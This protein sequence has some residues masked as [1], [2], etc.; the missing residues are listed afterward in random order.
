MQTQCQIQSQI[1]MKTI[2]TIALLIMTIGK[3]LSAQVLEEDV[4]DHKLM[5]NDLYGIKEYTDALPHL[6]WLSNNAPDVDE[7]VHIKGVRAIDK[8]LKTA[9]TEEKLELQ[10]LALKLYEQR[11]EHFGLN[12]KVKSLQLTAIYRYF[13]KNV[14]QYDRLLALYETSISENL[15]MMSNA[16]FL[17]YFD[18]LRRAKKYK[19]TLDE[20]L[21]LSNYAKIN[22]LMVKRDKKDGY[23]TKIESFLSEAVP[24]DCERIE[25]VFGSKL[26]DNIESL[27]SAKMLV[28]LSLKED[29]DDSETL[30]TALE[31]VS[32]YDPTV[33]MLT[34]MAKRAMKKN[35]LKD[36]EMYFGKALSQNDDLD[37][38]SDIYLNLAKIYTVKKQKQKAS[39]FAY[40]SIE[41]NQNKSAYTL[42]GNLYMS[43]FDECVGEKD[44]VVR[45][46]V[47]I[48]AYD[49]F[50]KANDTTN[51]ALAQA[52]FPSM[53]EIHMNNYA[54]GQEV[55]VDCWFKETV[56]LQKR[57]E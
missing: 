55:K 53:Q 26:E 34:Y 7:N 23:D 35:E 32:K 6:K 20:E 25:Q 11:I 1:I 52:N 9:P 33:N 10:E 18:I 3:N 38:E 42:I 41:A 54:L 48:A 28:K 40:K 49:M 31:I 51:M 56:S 30:E 45:R 19:L 2:L 17:S 57:T 39:E 37:V 50:K 21:V 27:G 43:S 29:C 22:D 15:E 13:A 44:L 4:F 47:F 12:P 8:I 14:S 36:A 24:L 5:F 16:N 46:A